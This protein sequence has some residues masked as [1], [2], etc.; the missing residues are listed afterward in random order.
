MSDAPTTHY[1]KMSAGAS[2]AYQTFGEGP[3][4]LLVLHGLPVPIDLLWDDPG[5]VRFRN[6]LTTFSRNIWEEDRGFG[7][8]ERNVSPQRSVNE[9]VEQVTSVVDAAGCQ[10]VAILACGFGAPDAIRYVAAHPE[11]VS[12]LVLFGSYASYVRD[13]ECSWGL[14]AGTLDR[15]V[16]A[17]HEAWG[18]A[19]MV[20]VVAPSRAGDDRFREWLGRGQR[21]ASNPDYAAEYLRSR[22][23]TDVRSLLP[24]LHVPTLVIHRRNDRLIRVDAG[25]Y[26]AEHIEG[27]KYVELPGEDNFLFAGDSDAALDEIEEHLTGTRTGADGDVVVSTVLFTDIANSTQRQA[28][29]GHRPWSK[30]SGEHD[31]LVRAALHRHRGR[32]IKTTGDGFVATFDSAGRAIRCAT[33]IINSARSIGLDVR[34]GVHTG[35]VEFRDNDVSGLAVSIAKRVCDLASAGQI[36]VTETV[37]G[38]V[39][40]TDISFDDRGQHELKGVPGTLQL[41]TVRT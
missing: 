8:S 36:F 28:A 13:D 1:T 16:A 39:I 10:R 2:I 6:R 22:F 18:T 32:E 33:E 19:S 38:T 21:L 7:A 34:A 37:R 25:R 4:D 27:A 17:S 5:L 9:L 14:P 12:S 31:A 24:D 20:D 29:L 30:L 3:L 26:L 41:H 15:L 23:E 40:G 11:R 35:E